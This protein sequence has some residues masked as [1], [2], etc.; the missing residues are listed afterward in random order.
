MAS[1]R[2]SWVVAVHDTGTGDSEPYE[3]GPWPA[4]RA[5]HIARGFNRTH[6]GLGW[7][8]TAYP[9]ERRTLSQL[10]AMHED[11]SIG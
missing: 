3:T 1:V 7:F 10:R 8:A 5:Q 6:E 11:N 2:T 9:L 4:H